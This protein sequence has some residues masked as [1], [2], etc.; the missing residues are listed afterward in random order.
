MPEI[1]PFADVPDIV[2]R[3]QVRHHLVSFMADGPDNDQASD[4]QPLSGYVTLTPTVSQMKWPTADPPRTAVIQTLRCPVLDGWLYPP[5]TEDASDDPEATSGVWIVATDQPEGLPDKVQWR[6][7]FELTGVK[8]QPAPVTFDVPDRGTVDLTT[9]LPAV[10]DPGVITVVSTVERERAEAAA[11]RAELAA[12]RADD[13]VASALVPY[14]TT[15]YVD[16]TV[17]D[18]DTVL[19][20]ILGGE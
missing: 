7:S 8:V 14:A 20:G 16:Q 18:I 17:G 5:D 12:E 13:M 6:A 11:E 3:G 4:E 2:R 19:A 10:P 15:A 9:V 1:M